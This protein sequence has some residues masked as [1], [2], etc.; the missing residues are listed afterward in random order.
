[1]FVSK[2]KYINLIEDYTKLA[3]QEERARGWY[4]KYQELAKENN[5]LSADLEEQVKHNNQLAKAVLELTRTIENEL[6]EIKE[7]TKKVKVKLK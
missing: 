6:K 7:N 5:E 3:R 2:K 1:M 4:N